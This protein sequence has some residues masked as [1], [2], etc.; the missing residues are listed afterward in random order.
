MGQSNGVLF[1]EVSVFRRCP[2]IEVSLYMERV[3]S[4]AY[5]VFQLYLNAHARM[6]IEGW[7]I[8]TMIAT[9][10]VNSIA[11]IARIHMH[12]CTIFCSWTCRHS[13]T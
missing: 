12:G 3:H 10:C 5:T 13:H 9:E 11:T 1:K 6:H 8:V 7:A 4:T 2:S